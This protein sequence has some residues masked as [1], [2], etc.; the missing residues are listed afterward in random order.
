MKYCLDCEWSVREQGPQAGADSSK[1]AID[2]VTETGH[3]ISSDDFPTL[4]PLRAEIGPELM[5][6]LRELARGG[7]TE[8]PDRGP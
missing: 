2:H 3:S 5:S 6:V 4:P 8:N 1:R 7:R